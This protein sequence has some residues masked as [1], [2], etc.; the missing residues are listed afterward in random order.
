M[1]HIVSKKIS[2][3]PRGY[4]TATT[5]LTVVDVDAALAFYQAAFGAEILTRLGGADEMPALH[6]TIKI[7]NS[8]IA[9]NREAPERGIYA[10]VSLGGSAS[11]VHLYVDDVDASWERAVEAGAIA[12]T[13]IY[14]AYWGDRTGILLDGNGHLWSI[15]S[16]IENVSQDEIQRRA[17]AS[18]VADIDLP[19]E[20]EAPLD[21]LAAQEV[22]ADEYQAV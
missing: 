18:L 13:P 22:V 3:I 6:A 14:D 9:L 12:H 17:H 4:R 11:Q 7:G 16:K 8:I 2:P 15:A 1:E 5:C 10:P 19:E 20:F 21:V